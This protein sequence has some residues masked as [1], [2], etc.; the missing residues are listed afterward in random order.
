MLVVTTAANLQ[1]RIDILLISDMPLTIQDCIYVVDQLGIRYLWVDSLCII[2]DSATDCEAESSQMADIYGDATITIFADGAA[3]DNAGMI[4]P[5]ENAHE[6]RPISG[7]G[8][9]F[10]TLVDQSLLSTRAWIFQERFMSRRILHITSE[11]MM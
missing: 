10:E 6:S 11:Q 9:S 3:D 1:A 2:Q 7:D 8:S 4:R 5:G